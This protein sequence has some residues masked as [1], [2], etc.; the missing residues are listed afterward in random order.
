MQV[1]EIDKFRNDFFDK[2]IKEERQKE[3]ELMRQQANCLHKYDQHGRPTANGYQSR[4][5]SKCGHHAIKSVRVWQ[6]T[7]NGSCVIS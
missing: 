7:Q 3:A 5:C 2:L 4:I 1:N 6:G